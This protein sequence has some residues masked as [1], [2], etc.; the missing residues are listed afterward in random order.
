VVP[1]SA[2]AAAIDDLARRYQLLSPARLLITKLDELDEAPELALAPA[3]LG[4]PITWVT[5]GQ[6]VPEDIEEP[7]SARL[8]E[9]ASTGLVAKPRTRT[10]R[11]A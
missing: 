10:H 6:A 4:L 7:T 2:S 1:A 5:T 3:R 11:A 9:L 8:L